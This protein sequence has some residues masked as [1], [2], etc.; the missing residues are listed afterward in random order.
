MKLL[1]IV[2]LL[3]AMTGQ[4]NNVEI[5]T[6]PLL[7][8]YF[9]LPYGNIYFGTT[10]PCHGCECNPCRYGQ[11]LLNIT[12]GDGSGSCA[13]AKGLCKINASDK[14]YCCPNEREGCCPPHNSKTG[15]CRAR[16]RYDSDCKV[17]QKC[18]GDCPRVCKNA[19]LT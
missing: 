4:S 1:I 2:G 14:V 11:P 7:P 17:R 12:C 18:C 19:T 9:C 13:A 5:V 15:S 10:P 16:C 8:C 3:A 6:C